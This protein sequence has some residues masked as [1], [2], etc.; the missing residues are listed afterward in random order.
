[1]REG[2]MEGIMDIG[3]LWI[4]IGLKKD[5]KIKK[6]LV[7]EKR[8]GKMEIMVEIEEVGRLILIEFIK[9]WMEERKIEKRRRKE[10]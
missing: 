5:K 7:I 1:M 3:I 9:K 2:I 8:W 10:V 4:I 6:E